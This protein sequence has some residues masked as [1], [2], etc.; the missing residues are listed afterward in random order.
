M[1]QNQ[2]ID[3]N[4]YTYNRSSK[5]GV[6]IIHGF[7]NSTYE[8]RDLAKYLGE[9]GY[10]T[11]ANNLPGHGTSVNDCN[12]CK[13]SD[14][15]SFVEQDIATMFSKCDNVFIAG[16][17]MGS[18][19]ALHLCSIFPIKAAILAATVL[20]FKDYIGI[21][22]LT[23]MLHK[24]ITTRE[25]SLSYPK[26][27]RDSLNF[28]GYLV[29]PMSAVNEMRKLT[30]KVKKELPLVKSPSLIIKST[31]DKLQHSNNTSLVYNTI[32]S[33]IKE[34]LVVN[35]VGHNLFISSPDQELIFKKI[36]FFFNKLQNI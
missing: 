22:I 36:L 8:T 27:I 10:Y 2:L 21:R 31:Q 33:S 16:I 19:L 26:D 32:S 25:K 1:S 29:W 11:V 18:V 13:Y 9:R 6:Y 14:W 4:D 35:K 12:K 28:H 15:I 5:N 17:S 7:T 3:S 24:I 23:P 34:K 20:E 30:N